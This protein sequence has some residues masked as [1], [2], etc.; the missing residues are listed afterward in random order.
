M[1]NAKDQD[2][3]TSLT[4]QVSAINVCAELQRVVNNVMP[5]LQAEITAIEAKLAALN[6]LKDLTSGPSDLPSVITWISK[7]INGFLNPLLMPI[8]TL[9]ARLAQLAAEITNLEAAIAA[10]AARI[11][12]CTI[13][14]PTVA[15]K[16][17]SPKPK[18]G[19]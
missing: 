8:E 18:R 6:P 4:A 2:F 17:A 11:E 13:T 14:V 5:E 1:A 16:A 9:T 10:A 15:T 19:E 12:N 7:F 3:L